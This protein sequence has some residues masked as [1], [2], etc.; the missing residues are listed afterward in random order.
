M[1]VW[2][3]GRKNGGKVEGKAEGG[4][5]KEEGRN[6]KG[7]RGRLVRRDEGTEVYKRA[8]IGFASGPP[9]RRSSVPL[10]YLI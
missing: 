1:R 3:E 10:C 4:K 6:Q 2:K 9:S 5:R 7:H 8:L